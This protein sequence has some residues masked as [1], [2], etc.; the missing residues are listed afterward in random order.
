MKLNE[1]TKLKA[2][3]LYTHYESLISD[4]TK[5]ASIKELSKECSLYAVDLIFD[6]ILKS[7]LLYD[8]ELPEDILEF[9]GEVKKQIKSL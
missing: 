4:F 8:K 7:H 9:W 2:K 1:L 6:N 5:G 3:E